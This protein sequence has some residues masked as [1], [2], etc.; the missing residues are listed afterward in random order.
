MKPSRP[1]I[2][3]A[4][5]TGALAAIAAGMAWNAHR[6]QKVSYVT[7][8]VDRGEVQRAVTASGSVNPEVTVQVGAFVS[9]TINALTCDYNTRVRKGQVC[10]TIDPRPYELT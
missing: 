6:A 2:L 5:L 10:A 8:R 1:W 9:G 7:A 3:A 4:C